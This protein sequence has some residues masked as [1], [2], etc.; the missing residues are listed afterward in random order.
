MNLRCGNFVSCRWGF[1][2]YTQDLRLQFCVDRSF[3]TLLYSPSILLIQITDCSVW[4]ESGISLFWCWSHSMSCLLTLELRF[5]FRNWTLYTDLS[6]SN[7][8][9]SF[10]DT[11]TCIMQ[12]ISWFFFNLDSDIWAVYKVTGS[13]SFM[14][15]LHNVHEAVVLP[16]ITFFKE[17]TYFLQY[18]MI[19]DFILIICN[20]VARI[21]AILFYYNSFLEA[22]N[23]LNLDF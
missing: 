11:S 9:V 3:I 23:N 18:S 14:N 12:S 19:N 8:Q 17:P 10:C 6:K 16:V 5:S 7:M 1:D 13:C 20:T 15:I 4:I 2:K 22:R 21:N